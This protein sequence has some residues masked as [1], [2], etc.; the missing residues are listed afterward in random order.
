MRLHA[1]SAAIENGSVWLPNDAPWLS[2]AIVELT[3]C[4]VGRHDDQVDS[5]S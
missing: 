2:G 1:Q 3:A 4:P 5:T